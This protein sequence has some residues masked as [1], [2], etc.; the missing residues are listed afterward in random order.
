VQP[1]DAEILI[2]G[3]RWD[4]PAGQA[5]LAVQLSPGRHHVEVRKPGFMT[6]S[7]DVLIRP[8]ATLTLNVSLLR[9]IGV[10]LE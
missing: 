4:S 2:D 3:E 8:G 9:N 6:Y 7:E 10:V 5:R 1:E